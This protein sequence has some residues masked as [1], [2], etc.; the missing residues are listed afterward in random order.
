LIFLATRDTENELALDTLSAGVV[1]ILFHVTKFPFL[2][3]VYSLRVGVSVGEL[4]SIALYA[5]GVIQ[6]QVESAGLNRARTMNEGFVR[7]D[8]HWELDAR[9]GQVKD[10]RLREKPA[11]RNGTV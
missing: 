8:G 5:E 10:T 3:G 7:L 6:F 11:A 4:R 9:S 2:P 1:S